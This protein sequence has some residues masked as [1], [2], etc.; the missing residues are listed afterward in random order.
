MGWDVGLGNFLF[1][2]FI[3][4]V[5]F[6]FFKFSIL[7]DTLFGSAAGSFCGVFG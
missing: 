3:L 6:F 1:S 7:L 5:S 4:S 2:S